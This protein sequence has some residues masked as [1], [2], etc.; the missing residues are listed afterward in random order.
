MSQ[1]S[2]AAEQQ[3]GT[4][5]VKVNNQPVILA[6]H[7]VTGLEIKQTAIAQHVEIESDFILT[8]EAHDGRP[9]ETIDD[10]ETITVTEQSEF[11]ANDG[12]DDS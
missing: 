4:V 10:D 2:A 7:R 5:T 9:A 12:D 6:K 3:H 1:T 8:L 11:S